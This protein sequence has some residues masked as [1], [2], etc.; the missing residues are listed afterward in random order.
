MIINYM[1]ELINCY[2]LI[3][4]EILQIVHDRVHF[5]K[6]L[7]CLLAIFLLHIYIQT[8][9]LARTNTTIEGIITIRVI[10]D[11]FSSED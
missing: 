2:I 10:N 11:I 4:I 5:A 9:A 6:Q 3:Q 7:P 8:I 1:K